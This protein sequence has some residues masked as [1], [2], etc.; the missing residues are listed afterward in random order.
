[1]NRNEKYFK[2]PKL[3]TSHK[4]DT[5]GFDNYKSFLKWLPGFYV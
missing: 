4:I 2:M 1:M 5:F 3:F